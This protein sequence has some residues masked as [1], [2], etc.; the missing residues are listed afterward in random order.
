MGWFSNSNSSYIANSFSGSNVDSHSQG[1]C[2]GGFIGYLNKQSSTTTIS[3]SYSSAN[4]ISSGGGF[5]GCVVNYSNSTG[6]AVENSFLSAK[7]NLRIVV[8]Q[9]VL[10]RTYYSLTF[11][12]I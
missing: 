1:G 2:H 11:I 7:F 3:N 6:Y 8:L 5:A 4:M 10:I 12:L 9:T